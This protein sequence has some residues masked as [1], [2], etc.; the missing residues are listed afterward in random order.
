MA[1]LALLVFERGISRPSVFFMIVRVLGKMD[2]DV[3]HAMHGL[4][5]EKV[6]GI[7]GG[8]KMTIHTVSHKALGI[9]HMG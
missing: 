3:F 9:V 2:D 5:V 7:V 4:G 6:E 1:L 8:G